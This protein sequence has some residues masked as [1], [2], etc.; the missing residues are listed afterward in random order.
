METLA[1]I[2]FSLVMLGLP[3]YACF[4]FI[5][6]EKYKIVEKKYGD[7]KSVFEIY[8]KHLFGWNSFSRSY[9]SLKEAEKGIAS[10]SLAEVNTIEFKK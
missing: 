6:F 1:I 4:Q 9:D 8:Q 10:H 2:L 7:G 3:I 5:E